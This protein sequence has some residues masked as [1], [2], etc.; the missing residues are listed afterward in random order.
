MKFFFK[1]ADLED[2]A[3][4]KVIPKLDG[5]RAITNQ[6]NSVQEKKQPELKIEDCP[7]PDENFGSWLKHQKSNWR[8]IR[9]KMK[10]ERKSLHQSG[11]VFTKNVVGT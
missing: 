7:T 10:A 9:G 5:P 2:I 1:T 3:K 8:T 6:T 4:A 11:S